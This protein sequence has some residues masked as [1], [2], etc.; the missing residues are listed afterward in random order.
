MSLV[1]LESVRRFHIPSLILSDTLAALQRHGARGHEGRLLWVGRPESKDSFRFLECWEPLQHNTTISTMVPTDELL[2]INEELA[3]RRLVLG[4]QVHSHPGS[5]YHSET[6]DDYPIC[7][8]QGSLSLVVP[9][10]GMDAPSLAEWAC[11][12][13][14][15]VGWGEPI[16]RPLELLKVIQDG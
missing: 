7:T 3:N 16:P 12:R 15:R 1:D 11:Y 2:R 6:D 13:L 4:A 14:R 8:Q 10:F 5:A 9:G